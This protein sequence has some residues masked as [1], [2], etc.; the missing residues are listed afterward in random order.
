MKIK[1]MTYGEFNKKFGGLH[2]LA[3]EREDFNITTGGF[4]SITYRTS[5]CYRKE[6]D[7][8]YIA[9]TCLGYIDLF[10]PS[11]GD[12]TYV[13]RLNG[14]FTSDDLVDKEFIYKKEIGAIR[15]ELYNIWHKKLE[16][17]KE[18]KEED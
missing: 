1:K 16:E 13:C 10:G 12:L 5:V 3:I 11:E 6:K 7:Y 18:G 8:T 17:R 9:Q 2:R 15:E 4:M 14:K